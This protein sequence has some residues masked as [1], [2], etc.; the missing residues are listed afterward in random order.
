MYIEKYVNVRGEQV[1]ISPFIHKAV[2]EESID[3]E[4]VIT[5]RGKRLDHYAKEY[6][7]EAD[8]WWI[9]AAASSI[10]WWLQLP[11]GVVIKIPTDLDQIEAIKGSIS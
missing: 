6:Y 5:D 2:A 3:Y 7:D 1:N 4:I 10:G 11:E 9:I 8:N